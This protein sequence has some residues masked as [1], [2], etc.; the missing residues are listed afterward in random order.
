M[1]RKFFIENKKYFYVS[2]T[3]DYSVI[4]RIPISWEKF[5][6]FVLDSLQLGLGTEHRVICSNE[7]S[8]VEKDIFFLSE[9]KNCCVEFMYEKTF[10]ES[11][12]D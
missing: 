10:L 5:L 4:K 2:V 3:N 12:V 7:F 9:D 8:N 11:E 6:Q 1:I